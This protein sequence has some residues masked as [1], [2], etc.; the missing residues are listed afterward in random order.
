M[1]R[2]VVGENEKA[3]R[4]TRAQVVDVKAREFEKIFAVGDD[5]V[6]EHPRKGFVALQHPFAPVPFAQT[7][8]TGDFRVDEAHHPDRPRRH[9][10]P[11]ENLSEVHELLEERLSGSALLLV[12]AVDFVDHHLERGPK[13]PLLVA[14]AVID[15]GARAPG[16]V[17]DVAQSG[18]VV[19]LFGEDLD[20]FREDEA[21]SLEAA[22]GEGAVVF[23]H[24]CS[25]R[26]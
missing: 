2:T 10:M 7:L 20:R 3:R 18:R 13:E 6:F 4:Q 11:D 16:D 24:G 5:V 22:A 1:R 14:E 9:E 26:G 25:V 21:A 15:E 17:G 19:T 8:A 12:G 23:R